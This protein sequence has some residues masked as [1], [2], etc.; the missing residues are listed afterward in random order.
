M[1]QAA[2]FAERHLMHCL[3]MAAK[4]LKELKCFST[5]QPERNEGIRSSFRHETRTKSTVD[6]I[7]SNKAGISYGDIVG[8]N[9]HQSMH[10]LRS[11][12]QLGTSCLSW[13]KLEV[14]GTVLRSPSCTDCGRCKPYCRHAGSQSLVLQT[15]MRQLWNSPCS[16][17][18]KMAI[19]VRIPHLWRPSKGCKVALCVHLGIAL[20]CNP[21]RAA[22]TSF[23]SK[24]VVTM[25]YHIL[26]RV[27]NVRRELQMHTQVTLCHKILHFIK[28]M[29]CAQPFA[30]TANQEHRISCCFH[31][32]N[33]GCFN[34]DSFSAHWK[35][36][37]TK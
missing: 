25:S 1:L 4:Y 19:D 11:D 34:S 22:V 23:N 15:Q 24:A 36:S 35:T 3:P 17:L 37:Q 2:S 13:K 18:T 28:I 16:L 12:K 27:L 33:D 14:D 10:H 9:M 21:N 8:Q 32:S 20:A 30:H 5:F 7:W 26:K 29:K 6:S 31:P